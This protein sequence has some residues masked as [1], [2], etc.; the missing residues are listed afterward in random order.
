MNPNL[1]PMSLLKPTFRILS[2][3][4][5]VIRSIKTST[6][7]GSVEKQDIN[8]DE[9]ASSF[10]TENFND[11]AAMERAVSTDGRERSLNRI[12]L[13]G[14]VGADPKVAGSEKTKV[15]IFSLATNEYSNSAV[16]GAP[17]KQRVDW[18]RISIFNKRLLENAEKYIRQGDRLYVTGRLHHNMIKDKNT[19][20][21]LYVTSIIADDMIFLTKKS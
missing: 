21:N 14:R 17:I 6:G 8:D 20:Q 15:V 18:H 2:A 11:R 5:P 7:K 9:D 19:N 1:D 16:D 4:R 12:E 10:L 3:F 13:I